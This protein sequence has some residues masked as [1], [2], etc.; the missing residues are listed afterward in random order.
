MV[1]YVCSICGHV[2]DSE[3]GE[4]KL[5]VPPGIDFTDLPNDFP[6][7]VCFA[8]KTEFAREG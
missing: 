6:C 8:S 5:D 2:Y 1:R 4:P 3:K 7:S